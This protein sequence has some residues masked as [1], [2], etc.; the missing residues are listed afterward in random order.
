MRHA[1]KNDFEYTLKLAK[2]VFKV[3]WFLLNLA[4]VIKT[5]LS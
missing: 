1:K 5:L 4:A 2:A 3:I